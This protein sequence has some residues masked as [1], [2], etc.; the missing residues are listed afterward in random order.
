VN[1]RVLLTAVY[2]LVFVP[3]RVVFAILRRDP[4]QRRFEPAATTYLVER[5]AEARTRSSSDYEEQ[6]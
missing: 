5:S 2:V 6:Y 1:T 4:L 3:F